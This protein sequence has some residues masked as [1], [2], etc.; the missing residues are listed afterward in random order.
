MLYNRTDSLD[1]RGRNWEVSKAHS[2]VRL[3]AKLIRN[4]PVKSNLTNT[5]RSHGLKV[6]GTML[7]WSPNKL[8]PSRLSFFG[9]ASNRLIMI[10]GSY[11]RTRMASTLTRK[12]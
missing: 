3:R 7:F 8:V 12:M 2:G 11:E 6:A 9:L 1:R 10:F 4:H 5:G